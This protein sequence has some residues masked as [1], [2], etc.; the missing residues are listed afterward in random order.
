MVELFADAGWVWN[1][2]PFSNDSASR[3]IPCK[4]RSCEDMKDAECRS[5]VQRV[6]STQS[7]AWFK[8]VRRVERGGRMSGS[9][10]ER[11]RIRGEWVLSLRWRVCRFLVS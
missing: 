9:V 4:S 11:V 1:V 7:R 6:M 8:R 5:P 10:G 2:F 3:I